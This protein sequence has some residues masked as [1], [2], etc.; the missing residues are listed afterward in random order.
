[1]LCF[2]V[3]KRL[4]MIENCSGICGCKAIAGCRPRLVVLVARSWTR[5]VVILRKYVLRSK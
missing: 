5:K 2:G 1:V 3:E 4:V